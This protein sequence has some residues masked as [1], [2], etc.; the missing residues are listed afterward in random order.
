MPE[1]GRVL[2]L[3]SRLRRLTDG[4]QQAKELAGRAAAA[5]ALL[6]GCKLWYRGGCYKF[7]QTLILLCLWIGWIL[8]ASLFTRHAL[9]ASPALPEPVSPNWPPA[10]SRHCRGAVARPDSRGVRRAASPPALPCLQGWRLSVWIMSWVLML[11]FFI[12]LVLRLVQRGGYGRRRELE[13]IEAEHPSKHSHL[14]ED[15]TVGWGGKVIVPR[16]PHDPK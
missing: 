13:D 3:P 14:E 5:P 16:P 6:Q 8:A 4:S 7:F 2:S 15:A 1:R 12:Q 10:P 9:N 11:C